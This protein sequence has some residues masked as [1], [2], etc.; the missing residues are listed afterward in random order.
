VSTRID[1]TNMEGVAPPFRM[2][3]RI[4]EGPYLNRVVLGVPDDLDIVAREPGGLK[5]PPP[6]DLTPDHL[7]E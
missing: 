6:P 5:L 1:I 4:G 7:L 2:N 3:I